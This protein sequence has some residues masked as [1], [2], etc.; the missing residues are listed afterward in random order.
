MKIPIL[1][2]PLLA[3][4]MLVGCG[5]EQKADLSVLETPPNLG[6]ELGTPQ[7]EK[8]LTGDGTTGY[9]YTF[10]PGDGKVVYF[11]IDASSDESETT[12]NWSLDTAK[13]LIAEVTEDE[14]AEVDAFPLAPDT[15][16]PAGVMAWIGSAQT[17]RV[18]G[19]AWERNQCVGLL[20]S[21]LTDAATKAALVKADEYLVRACGE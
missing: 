9:V 16:E 10:T 21:N 11:Q 4:A 14:P 20:I 3:A 13:P 1:V 15:A 17:G 6:T 5:S 12:A 18:F 19:Q 2:A 8:P 7:A